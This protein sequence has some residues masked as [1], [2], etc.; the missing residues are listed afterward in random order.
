MGGGV[1]ERVA[2]RACV[3]AGSA[4]AVEE[5]VELLAKA[6]AELSQDAPP[7]PGET[8]FRSVDGWGANA[9]HPVDAVALDGG[10]DCACVDGLN[11]WLVIGLLHDSVCQKFRD[12]GEE[13]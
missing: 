6:R 10:L 11:G 13:L 4:D 8:A 7:V 3:G 2:V 9:K 1:W 5:G 12:G